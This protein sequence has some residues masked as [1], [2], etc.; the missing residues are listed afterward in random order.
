[1][2]SDV[3]VV[4]DRWRLIRFFET[5]KHSLKETENILKLNILQF[6][7]FLR[8]FFR[9][10]QQNV[11]ACEQPFVCLQIGRRSKD[12]YEY[13]DNFNFKDVLKVC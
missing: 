5:E 1:M 6:L 8:V 3:P 12:I 11:E 9:A 10:R 7:N 13:F 2:A 4:K